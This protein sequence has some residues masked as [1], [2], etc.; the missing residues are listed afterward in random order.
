MLPILSWCR[1]HLGDNSTPFALGLKDVLERRARY[2]GLAPVLAAREL[3]RWR[4]TAD[5]MAAIFG[6]RLTRPASS[7][8]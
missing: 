4:L 7:P 6:T 8:P 2:P 5:K 3:G 1:R